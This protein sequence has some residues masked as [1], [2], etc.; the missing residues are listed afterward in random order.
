MFATYIKGLATGAGLIIAIGAQNAFVLSQGVRKN[1]VLVI[2]LICALC[3]AALVTLGVSGTGTLITSSPTLS[4]IAGVGGSLFLFLYGFFAFRSAFKGGKL[5]TRDGG[6][7]SLKTAVLATL[8]VTLLNPHVY[9]DTVVLLGCIASQF[10]DAQRTAFGAGAVTASF[11][12]FFS[13]SLGAGLL[14]PLFKKEISWRILDTLVGVVM[15]GI[16]YSVLREVGGR[17]F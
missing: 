4:L 5:S 11:V 8:A 16:G 7:T 14:A 17:L 9:M 3:D 15:W 13:L 6:K 12:W 1:H 2:P 10:P